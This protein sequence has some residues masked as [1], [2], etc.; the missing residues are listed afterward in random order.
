VANER[1]KLLGVLA[2]GVEALMTADATVTV[3]MSPMESPSG[4]RIG[5]AV[6]PLTSAVTDAAARVDGET[7]ERGAA[8]TARGALETA[9]S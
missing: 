9:A 6:R 4:S 3:V 8:T 5:A 1:V 2:N 7:V